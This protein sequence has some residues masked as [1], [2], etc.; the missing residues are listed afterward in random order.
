M[1]SKLEANKKDLMEKFEK[2]KQGK[3]ETLLKRFNSTDR[4]L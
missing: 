3:V 1:K 2:V 4:L